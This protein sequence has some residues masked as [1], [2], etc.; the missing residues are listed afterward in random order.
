MGLGRWS[1]G[2]CGAA[3]MPQP[4]SEIGKQSPHTHV[5]G[6]RQAAR[7]RRVRLGAMGD[8]GQTG[9]PSETVETPRFKKKLMRFSA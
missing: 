9:W 2:G 3:T 6:E 1:E 4:T 7:M 5:R 8:W